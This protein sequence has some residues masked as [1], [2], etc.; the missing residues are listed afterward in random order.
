MTM[1]ARQNRDISGTIP[2]VL[3]G[4][5]VPLAGKYRAKLSLLNG[6]ASDAGQP[7]KS[8]LARLKG[9]RLH[10]RF[11]SASAAIVAGAA[12]HQLPSVFT[13]NL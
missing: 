6:G 12:E 5:S 10:A 8:V 7:A 9:S 13:V 4:E 3:L 11:L 1:T 2:S